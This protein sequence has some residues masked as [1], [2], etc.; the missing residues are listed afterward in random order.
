MEVVIKPT[1]ERVK[2]KEMIQKTLGS[3]YFGRKKKK[4]YIYIYTHTTLPSKLCL[5]R[6]GLTLTKKTTV[7]F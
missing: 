5:G 7:T 1:E 6:K 2:Q 4:K 3:E